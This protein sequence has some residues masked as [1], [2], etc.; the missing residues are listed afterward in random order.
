MRIEKIYINPYDKSLNNE[1]SKFTGAQKRE[2]LAPQIK[3]SKST[4]LNYIGYQPNFTGGY[5]LDLEKTIRN[6][7][8]L[9]EKYPNIYPKNVREWAGM[10]LA[11]GNPQKDTLISIHRK[12]YSSMKDCFSLGELK[13]R[14]PEFSSV[15]SANDV[16]YQE[17][18][19]LSDLVN[20]K[21]EEFNTEEDISLQLLK[22]YWGE[23][24]SLND[25]KR[26]A[27]NRDLNEVM[28]K[29]SIPKVD[30]N[31]G[32]VMKFS[33]SEYN[34]RLTKQMAQ[35]R[36]ESLDIKAQKEDNE[37]VY[38]KRGPLSEEHKR[39][40]SEALLKYYRENPTRILE[41]SERQKQYYRDNP[42]QAEI[43]HRVLVKAWHIFNA[44]GIKKELSRFLSNN[45][46]KDF[47]PETLTNPIS[48]SKN[49]SDLMK[50]FWGTNEWARK[51]FSKNMEYAWKKVKE[52]QSMYYILN[53][54]PDLFKR[55]F[56]KW[57]A[58]KGIDSS[59]LD[60]DFIK[61]YPHN[62]K[63]NEE[64]QKVANQKINLYT[65]KFIDE[66]PGDE[67]QRL[68]NTYL[69]SLINFC[70]DLRMS[71]KNPKLSSDTKALST[72]LIDIIKESIFDTSRFI[73]GQPLVKVFGANEIQGVYSMVLR[74]LMDQHENVLIKKLNIRLNE[75]Y[76]YIS[77]T[78]KNNQPLLLP[79]N[80]YKY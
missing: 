47:K 35:K 55:N 73:G 15:K 37:P 76:N 18:S 65:P 69:L 63:A 38:I 31:Y 23:G 26:Y 45:G 33:D 42:E 22:L 12:L 61:Y 71:T 54:T 44:E 43:V 64:F 21:I 25:L 24:F 58:T 41:M 32:H 10:I 36:K 11:E 2:I 5:S 74:F 19:I 53:L 60:F 72:E 34:E 8:K 57:C 13:K 4:S 77:K 49:F 68:A 30:R 39:H 52:E 51:S 29:L 75:S 27:G 70:K 80:A 59:D 78:L 50:K 67:S 1:Q 6:L 40:I 17:G 20:G 3:S 46:V 56:Y 7:D 66:M 79:E 28:N 62:Q 14:F 16:Q 48:H 9:S